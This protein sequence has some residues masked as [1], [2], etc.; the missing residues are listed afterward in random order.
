M[1]QNQALYTNRL[2]AVRK[3]LASW[4]VAGV[5]IGSPA[6]RRWLSGFTG[7]NAQLLI[8]AEKAIIATDF[9][10]Y[11]QAA[12]QA[13]LYTLF[14]HERRAED[15]AAFIS[16]AAIPKIG[17]EANHTTLE[18]AQK[19]KKAAPD[20]AWVSLPEIVE[21]LRSIK[22][23][24]EIEDIRAAAAITDQAM[25]QVNEIVRPGMTERELAWKL[26]KTMRE[27]GAD[28]MAFPIIVASGANAAL[29]H[30]MT[31]H[32]RLQPGDAMIIDMGAMVNGYHSDM[33]RSF[34]LGNEPTDKFWNVYKLVLRAQT[35]VLTTA[36]PGMKNKDIYNIARDTIAQAG[37]QE[38]FGHGLGHGVGLN[39]HEDPLLSQRSA[40]DARIA[41]GMTL[42]VEPGVYIPGWGGIRIEDLTLITADGL[43]PISRCPKNPIIPIK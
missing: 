36:R 1:K 23:A 42:T 3:Q 37:H 13:P 33:T 19:L 2:A 16:S 14:K 7:S 32:R 5:L 21:P 25:L 20:V 41:A 6:N 34:F 38:H 15:T 31:S 30:H 18:E 27:A 17:L 8:T 28:S 9:R 4:D 22:T 40:E 43:T 12:I 29:P 39:I 26:E 10:Y 35:A 24:A 11:Q